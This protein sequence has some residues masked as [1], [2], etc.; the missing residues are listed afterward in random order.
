[1]VWIL[2]VRKIFSWSSKA[3]N[4]ILS[5][6]ILWR[7]DDTEFLASWNGR[8][9]MTCQVLSPS[10]DF[11]VFLQACVSLCTWNHGSIFGVSLL[12]PSSFLLFTRLAQG[13]KAC[14]AAAALEEWRPCSEQPCT[15]FYWETSAWGPCLNNVS[16]E[17]NLTA[18]QSNASAACAAMGVQIR[19][20][21]CIKA[22]AGPVVSKRFVW[23]NK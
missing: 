12:P 1:M 5:S 22:N 14:P 19:K 9:K 23:N 15:A 8:P 18:G 21:S 11:Q 13:G 20:V 3:A 7:K 10:L 6:Y 2:T 16:I 17:L 4:L